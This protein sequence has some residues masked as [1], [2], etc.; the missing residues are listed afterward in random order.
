MIFSTGKDTDFA[1]T[2]AAKNLAG[3]FFCVPRSHG[4]VVR[5]NKEKSMNNIRSNYFDMIAHG[6]QV[7]AS[8]GIINNFGSIIVRYFPHYLFLYR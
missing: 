4:R 5:V 8:E 7:R 2:F 3:S 6:L 1:D